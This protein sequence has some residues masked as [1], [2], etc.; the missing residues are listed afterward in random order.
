MRG[1]LGTGQ[2]AGSQQ[3]G[4]TEDTMNRFTA[5]VCAV[6]VA[7]TVGAA[8]AAADTGGRTA[9]GTATKV[10]G[11]YHNPL[12]LNLPGGS[13]AASCADPFVLHGQQSGDTHWYLYCTS[14]ALRADELGPDGTPL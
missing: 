1:R 13:R 14:D 7:G 8:P 2:G 12:A 9:P 11:A 5:A 3:P 4:C 10:A 6:L